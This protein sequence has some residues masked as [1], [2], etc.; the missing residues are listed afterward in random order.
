MSYIWEAL[1][2]WTWTLR[3]SQR[4]GSL[5]GMLK[6]GKSVTK[7]VPALSVV[8]TVPIIACWYS[9]N[10]EPSSAILETVGNPFL[11]WKVR[12]NLTAPK[13]RWMYPY[14]CHGITN[15]PRRAK[16][17]KFSL[18]VA[19][20]S[21]WSNLE[22]WT[23]SFTV[24]DWEGPIFFYGF[25]EWRLG[26]IKYSVRIYNGEVS[27]RYLTIFGYMRDFMQVV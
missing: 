19:G 1:V 6:F 16:V 17:M 27:N 10:L 9:K 3:A 14:F 22:V 2:I 11:L 12:A 5:R 8:W 23:Y 7:I 15:S 24:E 21:D 13:W 18:S 4:W 25:Y 20:I 26:F